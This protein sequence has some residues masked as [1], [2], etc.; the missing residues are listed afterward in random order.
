MER[1]ECYSLARK[2]LVLGP[3]HCGGRCSHLALLEKAI[4]AQPSA[5]GPAEESN[6]HL[7]LSATKM[8]QLISQFYLG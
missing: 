6:L 4:Y 7:A 1:G 3:R 8:Q 5:L 2:G